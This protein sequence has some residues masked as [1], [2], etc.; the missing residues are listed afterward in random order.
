M[1]LIYA[2]QRVTADALDA[3]APLI[4]MKAGDTSYSTTTL[5]NDPELFVPLLAN[6]T[7]LL[8]AF[9][10]YEG[11]TSGGS[12]LKAG[13]VVP[14]GASLRYTNIGTNAS[15]GST[16]SFAGTQS[17]GTF[18]AQTSGAGTLRVVTIPGSV[19]MG[20]TAGNVQMQFCQNTSN[21]TAT[22]VHAQSY[23]GFQRVS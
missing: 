6:A 5:T 4:A 13:W 12:D 3:L 16:G 21:A 14:S 17:S 19:I 9:L 22:I 20:A 18:T 7:Y 10:V 23:L 15:G 11:G 8:Q 1:L 2:G